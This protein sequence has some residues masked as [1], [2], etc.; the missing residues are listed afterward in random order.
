MEPAVTGHEAV[1]HADLLVHKWRVSQLTR[2]GVPRLLAEVPVEGE[3]AEQKARYG[4]FVGE[5]APGEPEQ[6]SAWTRR[7]RISDGSSAV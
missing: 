6:F 4:R 3:S 1:G 5:P 2:L 7:R